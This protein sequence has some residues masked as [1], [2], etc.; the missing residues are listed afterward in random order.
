MIHFAHFR[1]G[2]ARPYCTGND[3]QYSVAWL[4]TWNEAKVTCQRCKKHLENR[5]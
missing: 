2:K 4:V 1:D 5:R 3:E